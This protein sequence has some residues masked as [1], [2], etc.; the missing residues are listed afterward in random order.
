MKVEGLEMSVPSKTGAL[1]HLG[2]FII[3][4]NSTPGN[5]MV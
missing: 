1:E 2:N 4:T 3:G 5:A